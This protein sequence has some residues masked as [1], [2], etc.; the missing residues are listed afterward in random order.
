MARPENRWALA[1]LLV[2]VALAAHVAD[3]IWH[4]S[5]GLYEDVAQIVSLI[6]PALELPRFNRAVWYV[7]LGGALAAL[8][9]LT[10]LVRAGRRVMVPASYALA[11]FATANGVLHLLGA[12]ALKSAV[13]G[14]LTAP[15]LVAAGLF[16]FVAIPRTQ[17]A[18]APRA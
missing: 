6:Y 7:N 14:V 10:W 13:P 5:Y 17:G 8:L 12:A 18:A 1:W 2:S 3:E 4:G 9:A 11:T 15:L 16:L